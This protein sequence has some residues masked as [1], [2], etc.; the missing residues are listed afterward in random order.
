[1]NNGNQRDIF[2]EHY[3]NIILNLIIWERCSEK[4][5]DFKLHRFWSFQLLAK[6]ISSLYDEYEQYFQDRFINFKPKLNSE[7]FDDSI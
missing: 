3:T 7:Q 6:R 1:M 2:E 5:T 4:K